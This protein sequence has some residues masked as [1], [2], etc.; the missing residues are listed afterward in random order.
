M[1]QRD[2]TK[3]QLVAKRRGSDGVMEWFRRHHD[4]E[5]IDEVTLKV[6][7]RFK[8]SDLSGDEWRVS[9]R[10]SLSRKGQVLKERTYHRIEDAAA[11]LPWLLKTWVEE[12]P[13]E[14]L[15]SFHEQLDRDEELCHQP[16]CSERATHVYRLL[17]SLTS[18][19]G[20]HLHPQEAERVR[21]LRAFCDTH[22]VRGDS[23][24]EDNDDNYELVESLEPEGEPTSKQR[25]S[26]RPDTEC[27]V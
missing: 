20:E 5:F 16:G 27:D 3:V 11:H 14:E 15:H 9:T 10:V 2:T 17:G 21:F 19:R 23:D 8:T 6:E 12:L 22:K 25:P 7:P 4:D 26:V 24:L 13:E 1:K 18:A